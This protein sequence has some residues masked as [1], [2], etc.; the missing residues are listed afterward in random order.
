MKES[1]NSLF[2]ICPYVTAQRIFSGK[3]TILVMYN[4]CGN[5]LRFCEL[6]KRILGVTQTTLTKQLR[7]L[8][9]YGLIKRL[10]YA[11]VPPKVEYSLTEIGKEFLPILNQIR[12]FG[13][14]YI[15]YLKKA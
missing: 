6:Q 12:D 10:V 7:I 1:E 4:L 14:I 3:W 11:E 15:Q 2:G 13:N 5:T 8:E 9:D